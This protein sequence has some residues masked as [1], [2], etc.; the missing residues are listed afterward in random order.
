MGHAARWQRTTAIPCHLENPA[1]L[2]IAGFL[3]YLL[4]SKMPDLLLMG[5][6]FVTAG[7]AGLRVA[8]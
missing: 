5:K 6:W 7:F 3:Y 2:A 1:V 4:D 8:G